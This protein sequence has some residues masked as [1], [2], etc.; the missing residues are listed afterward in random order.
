[1]SS[2]GPG[3]WCT[4]VAKQSRQKHA[5]P[6][7]IRTPRSLRDLQQDPRNARRHTDRNLAMIAESLET[8]GA[9]RSIVIDETDRILAG[10]ATSRQALERGLKLKVVDVAG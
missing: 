1:M 10:N 4:G 6:R 8:V 2:A 5:E 3:A 7:T 9:A